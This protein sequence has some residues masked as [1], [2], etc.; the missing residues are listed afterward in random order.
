MQRAFR[1]AGWVAEGYLRQAWPSQDGT[2]HDAL[3][4]AI[5]RDDWANG[6]FTP[7]PC[8]I[9]ESPT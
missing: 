8:P 1:R 6:S 2:V 5:V 7:I 4:Y 9:E 3:L